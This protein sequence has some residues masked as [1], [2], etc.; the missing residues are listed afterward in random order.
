MTAHRLKKRARN[1]FIFFITSTALIITLSWTVLNLFSATQTFISYHSLWTQSQQRAVIHLISYM[2]T[3]DEDQFNHF[4]ESVGIM[5]NIQ[6]ALYEMSMDRPNREMVLKNLDYD[7][8]NQY[9]VSTMIYFM[10]IMRYF[11]SHKDI[12]DKWQN[13]HQQ[14]ELFEQLGDYVK[15]ELKNPDSQVSIS[16][17]LNL[18]EGLNIITTEEQISLLREFRSVSSLIRNVF[19]A[20]VVFISIFLVSVGLMLSKNWL[21]GFRELQKANRETE[22]LSKFPSMNPNPIVEI[23]GD[24]QLNYCNDAAL[25]YFPHLNIEKL[26]HPFLAC[27][28]DLFDPATF[29]KSNCKTR[30]LEI[31][32]TIYEQK[33]YYLPSL[34]KF[35][36]YGQDISQRVKSQN[37]L[38]RALEEKEVLLA[39]IHHRVKNNLALIAGLLELESDNANQPETKKV[40]QSSVSRVLSMASVHEQLY[41]NQSFTNIYFKS[42]LKELSEKLYNTLNSS[43]YPCIIKVKGEQVTLNVNQA[44]PSGILV[45]ELVNNSFKH[46]FKDFDKTHDREIIISLNNKNGWVF[47]TVADNGSGFPENFEPDQS[48]SLGYTLIQSLVQQLEGEIE[49]LNDQGTAVTFSFE[50]AEIKGSSSTFVEQGESYKTIHN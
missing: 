1:I 22:R 24:K 21:K 42:Y 36:I 23:T 35:H 9:E 50:K 12:F 4:R 32:E 33:I 6:K 14:V 38:Q 44:I 30:E 10:H 47:V 46:A 26:E 37:K 45:S 15:N 17:M 2:N 25:R 8:V 19:I 48:N 20:A 18:A 5:D 29:G 28:H 16:Q 43:S 27:N 41:A 31:D 49:F 3:G 11:S 7:I 13:Y 39:E 34:N 40:M